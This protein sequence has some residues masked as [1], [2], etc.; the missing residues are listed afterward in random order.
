MNKRDPI[1]GAAARKELKSRRQAGNLSQRVVAAKGD[2]HHGVIGWSDGRDPGGLSL[3]TFVAYAR[4]LG[5]QAWRVLRDVEES[6]Y[7]ED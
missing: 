4:G 7:G 3:D 2:V 5:T 1:L 6:V